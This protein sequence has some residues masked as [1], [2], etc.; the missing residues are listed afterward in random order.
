MS[1]ENSSQV[2]LDSI[3]HLLKSVFV[4]GFTAA[5]DRYCSTDTTN[6]AL[7]RSV[8]FWEKA[9]CQIAAIES[10]VLLDKDLFVRRNRIMKEMDYHDNGIKPVSFEYSE[11]LKVQLAQIEDQLIKAGE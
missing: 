11:H 4:E 1:D 9:A 7:G 8:L 10:K 5:S 3:E 6:E 2:Q